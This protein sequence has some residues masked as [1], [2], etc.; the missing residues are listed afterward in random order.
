MCAE[1][2][3][4]V[5]YFRRRFRFFFFRFRWFWWGRRS[6][7]GKFG[8]VAVNG[9]SWGRQLK[10]SN[11]GK[12]VYIWTDIGTVAAEDPRGKIARNIHV[13][14][15]HVQ[16]MHESERDRHRPCH[17]QQQSAKRKA[18]GEQCD[19]CHK[20][21]SMARINVCACVCVYDMRVL[22][23][24]CVYFSWNKRRTAL[25]DSFVAIAVAIIITSCTVDACTCLCVEWCVLLHFRHVSW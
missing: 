24:M 23:W 7:C 3:N 20:E 25:F 13:Y 18:A 1:F 11:S 19:P 16:R 22:V 8:A 21:P 5:E 4:C 10:E 9:F 12:I 14:I 6:V 15:M 2:R 17:T